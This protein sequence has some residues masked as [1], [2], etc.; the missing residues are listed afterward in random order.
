VIAIAHRLSTVAN[1]DR[2]YTVEDGQ[3]TEQGSHAELLDDDGT[4]AELYAM[5]GA[6]AATSSSG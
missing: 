5:Q 4:Y 3:V 2:I 6:A 1:A